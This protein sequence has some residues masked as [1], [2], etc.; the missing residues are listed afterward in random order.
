MNKSSLVL[1]QR[2]VNVAV[3]G[4]DVLTARVAPKQ[5]GIIPGESQCVARGETVA[6]QPTVK[7]GVLEPLPEAELRVLMGR[8][9]VNAE[10]VEGLPV[11][12]INP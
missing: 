3:T 10:R 11:M 5:D 2:K 6:S 1:N 9:L 7:F 12:V 4:G 8:S